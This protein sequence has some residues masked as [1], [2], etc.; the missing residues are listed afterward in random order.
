MLQKQK[1]VARKEAKK[2]ADK[3]KL[4][5][6]IEK[7]GLWKSVA[8]IEEKIRSYRTKRDK[9][10]HIKIHRC[11]ILQQTGDTSLFKFSQGGKSLSIEQLKDNLCQLACV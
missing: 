4:I 11:H 6:G 10:D 2:E 7:A 9:I 3:E 5:K 8:E 1:D